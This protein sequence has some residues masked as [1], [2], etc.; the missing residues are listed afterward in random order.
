MTYA[1]LS[2]E[3][4]GP[5]ARLWLDRPQKRNALNSLA[6]EELVAACDELQRR[7]AVP[8]VIIGGRGASFCA[9][10]DRGEPPARMAKGSGASARERR[11]VSQ[12]GRR[13]IEAIERLEAITIARLHGH[14]IGGGVLLALA[15]DLRIAAAGTLFHIPEVDLGIP[16]TWGGAPRL[17]R[18]VGAARAKELILLCDR[19][20]AAAAERY[21]LLNRVVDAAQLDVTVDDW[22]QRLAAKPDWALHMTKSQFQAYAVTRTLGDVSTLDGDLLAGAT[23]EDPSRFSGDWSGGGEGSRR[24]RG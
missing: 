14:V 9:G 13:A 8:V 20:D 15:C 23:G 22:A 7:W 6:L 11:W 18:E 19:F 21:G 12:I 17:A 1:T 24:G 3:I 5:V 4:D 2:L 16:L 10:A